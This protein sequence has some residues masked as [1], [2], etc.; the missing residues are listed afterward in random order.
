M[1]GQPVLRHARLVGERVI[2]RPLV[3]TD[4]HAAFDSVHQREPI[5]RWL[6][7]KGLCGFN[8]RIL[9]WFWHHSQRR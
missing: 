1:S 4:A 3:L 2:L 8:G 7:W 5:L 9:V 6:L